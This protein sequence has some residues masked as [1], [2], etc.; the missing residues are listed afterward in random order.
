MPQARVSPFPSV[1][2]RVIMRL[3]RS[4]YNGFSLFLLLLS[5][6]LSVVLCF[7]L[8]MVSPPLSSQ[9]Y[10]SMCRRRLSEECFPR[11]PMGRAPYRIC[12]ACKQRNR[13][14]KRRQPLA[15]ITNVAAGAVGAIDQPPEPEPEPQR[16]AIRF[17]PNGRYL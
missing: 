10:C 15:D 5:G 17:G 7:R 11:A 16:F 9:R 4:L 12:T 2:F 13:V 1:F 3:Y 6:S 8:Q 14:R